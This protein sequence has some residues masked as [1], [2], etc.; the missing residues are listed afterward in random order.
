MSEARKYRLNLII[1]H[2]YI[3]QLITSD[4][5]RVRD[6]V[7]GNVGTLITFRVGAD[8]AEFLAREFAPTFTEI[9][10]VNLAKYDIYLKLMIDGIASNPFS[11][12][13]LPPFPKTEG[14]KEKII[15][16]S[17]ERYA[18]KREVIEDKI[19]RWAGFGSEEGKVQVVSSS[20]D[21]GKKAEKKTEATKSSKVEPVKVSEEQR[22][23]NLFSARCSNCG[24]EVKVKFKPDGVRP[25]FCPD[26][27]QLFKAGKLDRQRFIKTT[28][29][30]SRPPV[31]SNNARANNEQ[32]KKTPSSVRQVI[33]EDVVIET[34][35]EISLAEALSHLTVGGKLSEKKF[36]PVKREKNSVVGV[37]AQTRVKEEP[38]KG[39]SS[40]TATVQSDTVKK[41]GVGGA[42][43]FSDTKQSETKNKSTGKHIIKPG[44]VIKF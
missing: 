32:I 19:A 40:F 42:S 39:D 10:L 30:A 36:G 28:P 1:A 6:A 35:A 11:A 43:H 4:S 37:I 33:A 17:R 7:F 16:V 24:K 3:A 20:K 26:C 22:K 18:T 13:T 21:G 12:T 2:Q 5:T 34:P 27:L 8:D 29:P 31:Q 41:Q 15:R 14:N 25:V 23:D 44:Q 9:D 38:K